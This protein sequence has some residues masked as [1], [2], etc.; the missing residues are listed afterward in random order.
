KIIALST[1]STVFF[2]IACN[3]SNTPEKSQEDLS[4]TDRSTTIAE[5]KATD[6]SKNKKLLK[7]PE[8]VP[9]SEFL[10]R[11]KV[12]TQTFNIQMDSS[13][14]LIKGKKGTKVAIPR[15]AF[16]NKKGEEV[17]GQ[18]KIHL[19]E[20]FSLKSMIG[21][22]L[23]TKSK[24]GSILS[25][26]GMVK[27]N[28]TKG[29]EK[30]ELKNAKELRVSIPTDN[31]DK[32]MQ[33]FEGKR[34]QNGNMKWR[35]SDRLYLGVAEADLIQI[36]AFLSHSYIRVKGSE[37]QTIIEYLNDHIKN[38]QYLLRGH[39]NDTFQVRA[40]VSSKAR[41]LKKTDKLENFPDKKLKKE[42][43]SL[44]F[45]DNSPRF[46]LIDNFV[47]VDNEMFMVPPRKE[48][49]YFK[50]FPNKK[51][52]PNDLN[53]NRFFDVNFNK[54]DSSLLGLTVGEYKLFIT[55][56]RS[57]TFVFERRKKDFLNDRENCNEM[58]TTSQ[59]D[60]YK[61]SLKNMGWLNVDKFMTVPEKKQCDQR[62]LASTPYEGDVSVKMYFPEQ[63]TY[64]NGHKKN[65][66]YLFSNV[67]KG[68]EVTVFAF[69]AFKNNAS[70]AEKK[71]QLSEDTIN[72]DLKAREFDEVD[73][74]IADIGDKGRGI[75]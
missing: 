68:N 57:E 24:Y 63:N 52:L 71:I 11:Y 75:Q 36:T 62:V 60:V 23:T 53:A 27:V 45:S 42:V 61:Y 38:K 20:C 13:E 70:I 34:D 15:N 32:T 48:R 35:S 37:Y 18:V 16:V 66:S 9:I 40:L 1:I 44:L 5:Q 49:H 7:N 26:D 51:N 39:K 43:A 67:P 22:D 65:G 17:Q 21:D 47:N 3:T 69:Q 59:K 4:S 72:L 41:I 56:K 8:Q 55:D 6:S 12:S 28:A 33:P 50:E 14:S 58:L 46:M 74:I 54:I 25:S 10:D 30:L 31:K 29:S 2:M 73:E 19:K 64:V